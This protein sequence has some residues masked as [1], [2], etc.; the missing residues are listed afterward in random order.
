M[1]KITLERAE[2]PIKS[3]KQQAITPRNGK[4]SADMMLKP[5]Q[6]PAQ[7]DKQKPSG[8]YL[9]LGDLKL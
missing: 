8:S 7:N 2:R 3:G 4:N 5:A 9:W 1:M 6:K